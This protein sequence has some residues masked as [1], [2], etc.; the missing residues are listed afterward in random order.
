ME[1]EDFWIFVGRIFDVLR[2]IESAPKGVGCTGKVEYVVY[3]E[4]M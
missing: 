3:L 1:T 2:M 4:S